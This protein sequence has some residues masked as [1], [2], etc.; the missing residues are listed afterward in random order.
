MPPGKGKAFPV[1]QT[2]FEEREAQFS[3]DGKWIAYQS[4]ETGR[5]EVYLQPFPGPGTK[6]PISNNG[7]AQVRWRSDGTELFYIGLDGQLMAVRVRAL[8]Q[9]ARAE[10]D[11]P[12]PLFFTRIVGGPVQATDPQ[13]YTVD[14]D[15][16]R[17]LISTVTRSRQL[18]YRADPELE[19]QALTEPPSGE[20]DLTS[21]SGLISALARRGRF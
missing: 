14:R 4:N 17:F 12:V 8:R 6:L 9:T 1:V 20:K 18:T 13:Q 21:G 5:F 19:S 15:G 16:Q 3:P 10:A 2:S 11:A 7:G